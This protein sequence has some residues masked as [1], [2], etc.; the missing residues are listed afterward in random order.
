M[1]GNNPI[2]DIIFITEDD[3]N[4]NKKEANTMAPDNCAKC[5]GTGKYHTPLKDGSIG[6]CFA[7]KGTGK[8]KMEPMT[9]AQIKFIRDLFKQVKQFMAEYDEAKLISDMKAHIAGEQ[10]QSKR[11]ASVAIDDLKAIKAKNT[12]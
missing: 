12:H 3:S 7:C 5:S 11:W 2:E 9:E 4:N 1:K 10:I 6:N 8:T